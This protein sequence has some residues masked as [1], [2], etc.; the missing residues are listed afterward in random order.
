MD[1]KM[2]LQKNAAVLAAD[3][4]RIGSLNRV[5]VNPNNLALTD[6]VVRPGTMVNQEDRVVPVKLVAKTTLDQVMLGIQAEDLETFPPFKEENI[7][8]TSME[9]PFTEEFVTGIDQNIPK[10]TVAIKVGASVMSADGKHVGTVERIVTDIPDEQSTHL[11][12]SQGRVKKRMKLI[13]MDWVRNVDE[14]AVYLLVY[15]TSVND[16]AD[17]L[18]PK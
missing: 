2:Q 11:L 5:V 13:P 17:A 16:L 3:G 15:K 4:Q 6:I 8:D 12:V 14:E 7:A 18:V 9:P 1:S 10:E